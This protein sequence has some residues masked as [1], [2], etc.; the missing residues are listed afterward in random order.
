MNTKQIVTLCSIIAAT[1]VFAQEPVPVGKGSYSSK[2]P[3][4]IDARTKKDT[5]KETE[6]LPLKLVKD[7]GS[8]IPSNK[9]YEAALLNQYAQGLWPMPHQVN[10]KKDGL[11]IFYPNKFRANG[12]GMDPDSPVFITAKD[13]KPIDSRVKDWTDWT[14]CIRPFESDSR[15]MDVTLAEGQPF[16]WMEFKGLD[17]IIAFGS[18]NV[19]KSSR[20]AI[21]SLF[22]IEG[23]PVS[24]PITTS[25]LGF[26]H[27]NRSYALF[28]PDGTKFEA[29]DDTIN[30]TFA[31]KATFL[32]LAPLPEAKDMTFLQKYA[33][34][35]PRDTKLSWN[36]EP[37]AGRITTTWKVTAEALQG[38]NTTVLQGFIP[39]HYRESRNNLQFTGIN[40][41]TA[42]GQMKC[43]AG[44]EFILAYPFNGILPN[45]PAPSS[46]LDL[47][48]MKTYFSDTFVN[49]KG[50]LG[51]DTYWGGKQLER[52]AQ[53]SFIA[54][55]IKDPSSK[56]INDKLR[57]ELVN[58]YTFTPGEK[59][60]FFAWYPHRKGLVGFNTSYGS[61]HF[62]DVHFHY[63]YFTY[64]TGLFSQMDPAFIKDYGEMARLVAKAYA[65]WDRNDKRFPFFRTFDIWRGHS[66]AGGN[67]GAPDG[68]N[69]ESTSEA[70]NSWV[71]LILLGQALKD[72]E[73]TAA[74]VMGYTFE[75]RATM[76]YWFNQYGDNFPKE[77]QHKFA[78]MI[79]CNSIVW[80]TWFSGDP[81]WISGIQWIPT[82]PHLSYFDRDP[83]FIKKTHTEM[84][85][86]FEINEVKNKTAAEQKGKEYKIRTPE[87]K[88]L[89]LD[90]PTYH[91]GFLMMADPDYALSEINKMYSDPTDKVAH[92]AWM[93]NIYYQASALKALGRVDF[94][95]YGDSP[96]SMVYRNE[97]GG[98]RTFVAWNP[99]SERRNVQ[100]FEN[101][102]PLGKMVAAPL[103]ITSTTTL[104]P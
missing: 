13:F 17:P 5:V 35:I 54:S 62:T 93:A 81:A 67:G 18:G 94:T 37:A 22:D 80:G 40:Y 32:V 6:E 44:N 3:E 43:A 65:N 73:M 99:T 84:W 47:D 95:C 46:G 24:L 25:A 41:T 98:K 55:Q 68:N 20:V 58:W 103:T 60:H 34:A 28:A 2:P 69:Q 23:K 57:A 48:R 102:K 30:V 71:G 91:L 51:S 26:T 9:W 4:R 79:W 75:S 39:H 16:V 53:A 33:Y 59:D 56:A 50:G 19:Y 42:R 11:E 63:G 7:D 86:E 83:N 77:Y 61:E 36:Y 89:G 31:G 76:E 104:T 72:P 64:A 10:A 82:G 87:L 49:A 1:G 100:F 8:A 85:R 74:G 52:W 29:T 101:G 88:N 70:T 14:V 78:G 27:D 21:P 66:F 45:L 38:S 96:T 90:L 92:D 12:A 97:A 15:Y